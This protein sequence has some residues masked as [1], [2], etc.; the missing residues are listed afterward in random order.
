MTKT[1]ITCTE[2]GTR[3]TA[4]NRTPGRHYR[5]VCNKC[6]DFWGWENC[7][8]DGNHD[9]LPE[10]AEEREGCLVCLNAK[11][12]LRTGHT[13]TVAKTRRSHAACDHEVT[14]KA[15]AACRKARAA[16]A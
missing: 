4:A 11:P 16:S 8:E 15:R 6:Y 7:H 2:C 13:N 5:D 9:N 3:I 14:P 1:T 12:Q 10:D